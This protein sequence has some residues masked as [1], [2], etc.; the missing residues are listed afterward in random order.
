MPA[1]VVHFE[2]HGDLDANVDFYKKQFDWDIQVMEM[3]DGKYGMVA[4]E[5][6]KPGIGGG[7]AAADTPMVTIYIEVADVD[8]TLA[9]IEKG[10]GKIIQPAMEIP[11]VVTFGLFA[12]PAGN[13][14]GLV[15]ATD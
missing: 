12:D 11:D 8:A 9:Q 14:I 13:T 2:I 15:K 7:L 1:P 10:G 4:G 5:E 3:P 6:G